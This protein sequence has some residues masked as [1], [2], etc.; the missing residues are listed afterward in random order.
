[1]NWS[2]IRT[3]TLIVIGVSM[4]CGSVGGAALGFYAF[5]NYGQR[6][7]VL[8]GASLFMT[9]VLL[10]DDGG[11]WMPFAAPCPKRPCTAGTMS[12]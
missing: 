3:K 7:V 8:Q 4:V 9:A 2:R 11:C 10:G 1:M 6:L 5:H 12:L